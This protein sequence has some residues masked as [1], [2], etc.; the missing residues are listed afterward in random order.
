MQI[1][2]NLFFQLVWKFGIVNNLKPCEKKFPFRQP[3]RVF[4]Q[5][6]GEIAMCKYAKLPCKLPVLLEAGTMVAILRYKTSSR[7]ENLGLEGQ[8]FYPAVKCKIDS[9]FVI[10]Y[11]SIKLKMNVLQC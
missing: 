2:Y 9:I 5:H 10:M 8:M 6:T 3:F 7:L 4:H 11:K 1:T